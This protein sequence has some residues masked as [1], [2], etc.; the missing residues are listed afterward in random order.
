MMQIKKRKEE[1]EEFVYA[2]DEWYVEFKIGEALKQARL[3]A[4]ITQEELAEQLHNIL[5]IFFSVY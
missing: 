3:E 5:K 1:D 2:Y 4:G